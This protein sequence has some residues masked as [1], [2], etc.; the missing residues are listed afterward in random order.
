M[1]ADDSDTWA[2]HSVCVLVVNKIINQLKENY[3]YYHLFDA[4]HK[5]LHSIC[6]IRSLSDQDASSNADPKTARSPPE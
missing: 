4:G 3:N 2:L 5:S 6:L 1:G